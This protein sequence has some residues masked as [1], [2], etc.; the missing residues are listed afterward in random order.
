MFVST[1]LLNL[2][3]KPSVYRSRTMVT[4]R[5]MIDEAII[6][7]RTVTKAEEEG[8]FG[9]NPKIWGEDEFAS[10]IELLAVGLTTDHQAGGLGEF[11]LP[12]H[13]VVIE[14]RH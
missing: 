10:L 13:G 2:K 1:K 14:R 4:Y 6:A 9:A 3:Y 12:P 5:Y 11:S 8:Y 7:I